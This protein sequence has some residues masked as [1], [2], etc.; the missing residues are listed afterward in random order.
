MG[1]LYQIEFPNGKSYIGITARKTAEERFS[2]HVYNSTKTRERAV[3]RAI[4]KYGAAFITLRTL[5]IGSFKYLAEL[6]RKAINIYGTFGR[7]GYNMTAGGEGALGYK[8][9][10]ESLLK[11]GAIHKGKAHHN[12]PHSE[13][14]K[15]KMSMSQRGKKKNISPERR[16]QLCEQMRGNVLSLGRKHSA[17]EREIHSVASRGKSHGAASNAVGVSFYKNLNKF[18]A[19]LTLQ[20]RMIHLGYHERIEDAI[21][22]RAEGEA[23]YY[24]H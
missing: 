23:K 4:K 10:P 5:A 11:M 12:Q 6:E 13:Q 15:A 9:T 14:A 7:G 1:C 20:T 18:R 24:G 17:K 16:K 21:L 3:E 22:A 8:H 19:H 2:E